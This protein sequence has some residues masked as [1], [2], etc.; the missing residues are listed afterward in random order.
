MS[1]SVGVLEGKV[2]VQGF[3]GQPLGFLAWYSVPGTLEV[4]REQLEEAFLASG[5]SLDYLPKPIRVS[6]A[7]RR[8]TAKVQKKRI[9]FEHTKGFVNLEVTE[10]ANSRQSVVRYLVRE[11]VDSKDV[12]LSHENAAILRLNKDLGQIE[13]EGLETDD[14][15]VLAAIRNA[16]ALFERC[17][18][19]YEGRHIRDLIWDIL[20]ELSPVAVRPAGGVYFVPVSKWDTLE[21]LQAAA[22]R[23]GAEFFTL[24]VVDSEDVR[25]MVHSKLQDQVR[26]TLEGLAGLLKGDEPTKGELERALERARETLAQIREYRELLSLGLKDLESDAELVELQVVAALNSL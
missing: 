9:P 8:A 23:L 10:V 3:T 6:H 1:M 19:Y 25:A 20:Q 24:P 12:S 13:I 22:R 17:R 14:E 7:F 26:R 21:P 18:R 2:V 4:T 5:L 11:V 16:R 15:E